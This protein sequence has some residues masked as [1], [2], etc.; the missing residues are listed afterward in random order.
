MKLFL[1]LAVIIGL[2]IAFET[3]PISHKEL[4]EGESLLKI[5]R[6]G[7]L[8]REAKRFYNKYLPQSAFVNAWPE[9]KINNYMDS[10]YYGPI[11]IG[12]PV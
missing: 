1:A 2:A 7:G 5:Y 12:T 10:Q 9:V 3:I 6:M 4:T 11:D 8:N